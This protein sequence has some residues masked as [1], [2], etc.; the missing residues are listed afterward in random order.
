[1]SSMEQA[2]Q[3]RISRHISLGLDKFRKQQSWKVKVEPYILSSNSEWVGKRVEDVRLRS[4]TGA[5]IA[6]IERSG[7]DLTN[8]GPKEIFYPD[9]HIFL[10]GEPE[11]VKN[12]KALLAKPAEEG[13]TKPPFAFDRTIIPPFSQLAG[14]AIKDSNIRNNYQVSIVGIQRENKH[15][16]SPS[17]K[18]ILCEND[19]LLLMG[20]EDSLHRVKTAIEKNEV[21]IG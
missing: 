21:Q 10:M 15:I 8:I 17:A 20:R 16:A 1:M 12:A 13:R 5:M 7:F 9:D 4:E 19:V 2:A 11:Q 18:E 3:Q 6:G 14:N